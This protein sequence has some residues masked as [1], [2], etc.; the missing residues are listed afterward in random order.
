MI[1]AA[2]ENGGAEDQGPILALVASSGGLEYTAKLAEEQA[3]HAREAL[4]EVPASKFRDAL[5]EL[6][7]FAVSRTS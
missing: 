3:A 4:E 5:A 2:I 6:A 7:R 1:R